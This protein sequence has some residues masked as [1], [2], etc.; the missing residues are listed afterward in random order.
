MCVEFFFGFVVVELDCAAAK[1]AAIAGT[2]AEGERLVAFVYCD[3]ADKDASCDCS[4]IFFWR[5][6][7]FES[8]GRGSIFGNGRTSVKKD[9]SGSD[10]AGR[11][12]TFWISSLKVPLNIEIPGGDISTG[13]FILVFQVFR[14]QSPCCRRCEYRSCQSFRRMS[15]KVEPKDEA[16]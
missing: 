1:A 8:N 3:E 2:G 12:R 11:R 5:G 9:W 13:G 6:S 4:S 10:A 14:M 16:E 7:S 15:E